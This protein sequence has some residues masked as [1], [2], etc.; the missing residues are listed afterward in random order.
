MITPFVKFGDLRQAAFKHEFGTKCGDDDKL[1][2]TELRRKIK[3]GEIKE[4][5]T[6]HIKFF[7][8]DV[9]KKQYGDN[10]IDK[11]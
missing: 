6:S 1:I 4:L 10:T 7:L 2:P 8:N 9:I 11:S 5:Q 3:K